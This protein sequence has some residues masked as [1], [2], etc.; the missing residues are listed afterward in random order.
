MSDEPPV[1][2][3]MPLAAATVFLKLAIIGRGYGDLGED[4]WA[5]IRPICQG[6]ARH[7]PHPDPPVPS[8][9]GIP[10]PDELVRRLVSAELPEWCETC[11]RWVIP[12]T[13]G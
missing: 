10:I 12:R 3:S 2:L 4:E 1:F 6:W 7:A 5:L 8:R 9:A 13:S 11:S